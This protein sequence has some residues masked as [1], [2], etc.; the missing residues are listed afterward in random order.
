MTV[1]VGL[2]QTWSETLRPIFLRRGA[3]K[4]GRSCIFPEGINLVLATIRGEHGGLVIEH[5]LNRE[6][7]GSIPTS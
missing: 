4:N 5:T 2:C 3:G 6:V 7:L 1:K